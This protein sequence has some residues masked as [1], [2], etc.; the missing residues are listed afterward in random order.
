MYAIVNIN[1]IQTRVMR[2]EILEIANLAAEPGKS[3]KF[4][5]VLM[6]ADGDKISVG[7]P[8]VKGASATVEVVEHFRGPK[9]KIYKFK[10]RRE[11]RRRR[12]YRSELTRVRVTGIDV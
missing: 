5:Q 3:V 1:G 6:V 7:Q 10:R 12:G 9:L 11:Y 4:D 2:D 8:F